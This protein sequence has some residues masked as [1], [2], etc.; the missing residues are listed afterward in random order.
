MQED[1]HISM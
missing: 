1:P